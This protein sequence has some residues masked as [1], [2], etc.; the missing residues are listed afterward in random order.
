M[1]EIRVVI[2]DDSRAI[3]AVVSKLLLAAGGHEIVAEG[4][5]ADQAVSLCREHRPD[6]LVLDVE[7]PGRSGLEALPQIYCPVVILSTAKKVSDA[8]GTKTGVAQAVFVDKMEIQRTD[9]P[10]AI[11]LAMG[12]RRRT[13]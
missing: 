4:S 3:R 12:Q 5:T 1:N 9:L 7:M 6:V 13:L 10:K 8:T 11:R 2:V